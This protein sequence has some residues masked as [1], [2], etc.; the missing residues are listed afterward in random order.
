MSFMVWKLM[1]QLPRPALL[2]VL[3]F[4]LTSLVKA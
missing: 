3:L 2:I 1:R 4:V